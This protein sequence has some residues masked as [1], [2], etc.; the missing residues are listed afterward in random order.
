MLL[1]YH[2]RAGRLRY[3]GRA[4]TGFSAAV[5]RDLRRRLAELSVAAPPDA[6]VV[7]T[8]PRRAHW[9]RPELVAEVRFTEWTPERRLRHPVFLGLREDKTGRDVVIATPA[10]AVSG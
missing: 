6:A 8:A 1:G 10:T 4:G 5:L 7:A 9:V 3:A 2:D